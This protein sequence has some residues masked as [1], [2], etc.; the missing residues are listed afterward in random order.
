[1]NFNRFQPV[2]D[3]FGTPRTAVAHPPGTMRHHGCDIIENIRLASNP[4]MLGERVVRLGYE[5]IYSGTNP[6]PAQPFFLSVHDARRAIDLLV[7]AR[8]LDAWW[9]LAHETHLNAFAGTA[10]LHRGYK[11]TQRIISDHD[12]PTRWNFTRGFEV[13][14]PQPYDYK[15]LLE[16]GGYF[17]SLAEAVDA[18]DLHVDGPDFNVAFWTMK[19]MTDVN[20]MVP[21][22][23]TLRARQLQSPQG[24][25]VPTAATPPENDI[26]V[27]NPPTE[28]EARYPEPALDVEGDYRGFIYLVWADESKGGDL[29]TRVWSSEQELV[30]VDLAGQVSFA[31]VQVVVDAYYVGLDRGQSGESIVPGA[32]QGTEGV[33]SPE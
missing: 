31:T 32:N 17:E 15:P 14:L 12:H 3:P 24:S 20:G 21:H 26:L 25:P 4:L 19:G 6:I 7:E 2:Q 18:V 11:V 28:T 13:F 22:G 27:L 29:F 8:N 30:L 10:L 23:S 9:R 5:V 1:M 16:D 33:Q